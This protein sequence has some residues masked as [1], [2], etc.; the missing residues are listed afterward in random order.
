[1][2]LT[3]HQQS[4][5]QALGLARWVRRD[6]PAPVQ[7]APEDA[8][9]EDLPPSA[10]VVNEQTIEAMAWPEI[11][12]AI[13][14]C[15]ACALH[16]T[17][18]QAVVGVGNRQADWM[19]VGEAPGEQEDLQGEPF[20]GRAGV[21]LNNMLA[22]VGLN[23][24]TVY[25]ANVIKCRPPGNRD[26]HAEELSSCIGYLER[27]I[28]LVRPRLILIVGRVAAQ[29]LLHTDTAVGRLRGRVH[30][31]G[32]QKIPVV[33][34]YHP[35]YLLRRPAEKAKSWDD[36]KLALSQQDQSGD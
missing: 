28:A 34:T 25:I 18:Q 31:L 21:L 13:R 7:L 17:R 19:I 3:A 32:E 14:G 33:V 8:A 6:L 22:A 24:E 4:R 20:V 36:L 1:M 2:T 35:A 9:V 27:Q 23:R 12:A 26:P 10:A 5:L 15:T 16:A 11:E 29:T 30:Y